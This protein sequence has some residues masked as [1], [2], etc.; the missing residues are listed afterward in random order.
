MSSAKTSSVDPAIKLSPTTVTPML[1]LVSLSIVRERYPDWTTE[2][3]ATRARELSISAER[4]SRVK[5][6]VK[7]RF[8]EL[9]NVAGSPGRRTFRPG[10]PLP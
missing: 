1:A 2:S 5:A 8:E 9:V 3:V 10:A 4:V 7:A 6:A